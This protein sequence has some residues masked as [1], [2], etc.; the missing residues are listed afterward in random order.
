LP[1]SIWLTMELLLLLGVLLSGCCIGVMSSRKVAGRCKTDTAIQVKSDGQLPDFRT[2]SDFRLRHL[3][4]MEAVF[5]TV[6]ELCREAGLASVGHRSVDGSKYQANASKHKVFLTSL[7]GA[8]CPAG[9]R[10]PYTH[11]RK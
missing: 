6:L 7:I 10:C 4:T 11:E 3:T 1:E 5:V 2:L 9:G 8:I